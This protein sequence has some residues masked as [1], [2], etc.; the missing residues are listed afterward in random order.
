MV[1]VLPK[2]RYVEDR[3]EVAFSQKDW[4]QM[5]VWYGRKWRSNVTREMRRHLRERGLKGDFKNLTV[6]Q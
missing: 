5:R 4:A 3:V 2:V 1:G 6:L